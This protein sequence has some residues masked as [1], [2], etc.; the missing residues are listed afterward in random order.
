MMSRMWNAVEGRIRRHVPV[1]LMSYRSARD[2]YSSRPSRFEQLRTMCIGTAEDMTRRPF[3]LLQDEH[4]QRARTAGYPPRADLVIE[5]NNTC[6]IDC[7]MCK[8]S[9]STRPKGAMKAHVLDT[10]A[11]QAKEQGIR[12]V[13]LHTIGDPL[14]NPRL[15][16][17]LQILRRYG[18]RTG[19]T[20]N[21]LLLYRHIDT[22]LDF[23]DVCSHISFSVDGATAPVY[24]QIRAGGKWEQLL[25]NLDLARTRLRP[26]GFDVRMSMV[27]S[28]ANVSEVGLFIER[29][30][31][32]VT[33]PHSRLQFS[34][35]NSLSPD[36]QYF[37]Q[38][39]LFAN[40]TV[41]NA[42]CRLVMGPEAH[43]LIDGR[44]S[45]CC[46]DYDGSLVIGNVLEKPLDAIFNDRPL[47]T[48]QEA[49]YARNLAGYPLCST[50]FVTDER[51]ARLLNGVL[52]YVLYQHPDQPAVFYQERVDRFVSMFQRGDWSSYP[53]L[54][55]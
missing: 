53:S 35:V 3:G 22:L 41:Q 16:D 55:N 28:A 34:L 32:Y 18:L 14:A 24:E 31:D 46:R 25:D 43:I 47:K 15:R 4:E 26:G 13:E 12:V 5:I 49:H 2:L 45:V 8:T 52:S 23:R 1:A 37:D 30:R 36:N 54:F 29:F 7:L 9:L 6:N 40:H 10:A 51:L 50:C 33:A 42:P 19:I 20:T 38:T 27:V 48:L 21:G 44:V 11:R 17:V 39:N